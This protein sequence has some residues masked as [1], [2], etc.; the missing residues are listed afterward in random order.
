ML[1]EEDQELIGECKEWLHRLSSKPRYRTHQNIEKTL[2]LAIQAVD[3]LE[4]ALAYQ[5]V[6]NAGC[7]QSH[8]E[9]EVHNQRLLAVADLVTAG[10][11]G[12]A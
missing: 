12:T 6:V 9:L 4:D 10:R 3:L 7:E 2:S 5:Q 11:C 1:S 8:D